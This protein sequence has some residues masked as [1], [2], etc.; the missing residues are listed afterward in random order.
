MSKEKRIISIPNV[1]SYFFFS[2]VAPYYEICTDA[3]ERG[4]NGINE[5][6][7]TTQN[8]ERVMFTIILYRSTGK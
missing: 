2:N 7:G 5:L 8:I 1:A 6:C 3:F 4:L